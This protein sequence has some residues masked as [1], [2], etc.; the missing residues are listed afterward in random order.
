MVAKINGGENMDSQEVIEIIKDYLPEKA[1]EITE[2]LSLLLESIGST[3]NEVSKLS[4]ASID[5]RDFENY[6]KYGELLKVIHQY[7]TKIQQFKDD[8]DIDDKPSSNED[9]DSNRIV[10]YEQYT[11]DHSIS[12]TLYENF[13]FKRPFAFEIND[14]KIEVKTWRDMLLET[15]EHLIN[16]DSQTFEGFLSDPNMN[17]KKTRYFTLDGLDQRIPEKLKQLN[18]YVETNMGAN[19]IRN[20]IVKMLS[21]YGIKIHLYKVYFRADYSTLHD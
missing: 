4:S 17:G 6:N 14:R 18:I 21:K 20:L 7:E 9:D 10:N 2:C 13:T 11:V 19:S 16:I 1:I 3:I 15:C 5:K 8:L 12:H